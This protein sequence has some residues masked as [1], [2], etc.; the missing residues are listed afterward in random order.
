M[1]NTPSKEETTFGS[2]DYACNIHP[3]F[4][5]SDVNEWNNHC[6]ET[7]HKDRIDATP[8]VTCGTEIGPLLV[9]FQPVKAT[10]M[11]ITKDIK[12]M[13]NNCF[14]TYSGTMKQQQQEG[15]SKQ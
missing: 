4:V 14:D 2:G 13:C 8:C 5:T 1:S 9:P 10:G 12:L 6:I 7:G 3:G 11:G 15:A